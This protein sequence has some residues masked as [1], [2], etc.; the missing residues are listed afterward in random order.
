M[1]CSVCVCV[2]VFII[3]L[4]MFC[5]IWLNVESQRVPI[6]WQGKL[7]QYVRASWDDAICV[8]GFVGSVQGTVNRQTRSHITRVHMKMSTGFENTSRKRT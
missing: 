8:E 5:F 4:S 6:V 2:G 7:S 1:K 3:D